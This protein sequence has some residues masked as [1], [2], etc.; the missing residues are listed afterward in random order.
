M[1]SP[2]QQR[3]QALVTPLTAEYWA[4]THGDDYERRKHLHAEL[5]QQ[6]MADPIIRADAITGRS[7]LN[8]ELSPQ[9]LRWLYAHSKTTT[10]RAA[11][12]AVRLDNFI[13]DRPSDELQGKQAQCHFDGG[14]KWHSTFE[15][16]FSLAAKRRVPNDGM[17]ATYYRRSG[18][19][20]I[21]GGGN[22]RLLGYVLWG[23]P[24]IQP[25][26][27]LVC[28]EQV[29]ADPQLNRAFHVL[30]RVAPGLLIQYDN[31]TEL[32]LLVRF[33]EEATLE[34]QAVLTHYC[35][36]LSQP[37]H[38]FMDQPERNEPA[39]AWLLTRLYQLQE[40][41]G[42]SPLQAWAQRVQH[43]ITGEP[44][45]IFALWYSEHMTKG[46]DRVDGGLD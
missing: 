25:D 6:V 36:Y 15:T 42:R 41:Q 13:Y 5:R 19:L 1:L 40:I 4:T 21:Y 24:Q 18:I 9:Y 44:Q 17:G 2:G 20:T 45:S 30:D 39:I 10:I 38:G 3:I 11:Y 23:E 29:P 16:L 43:K 32:T 22:H 7:L 12:P 37:R 35:T 34:E 46:R 26:V 27:M 14:T 8:T 28:D 33:A 31:A